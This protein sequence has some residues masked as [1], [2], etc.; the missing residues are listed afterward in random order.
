ML[1]F[2]TALRI[3]EKQGL[4]GLTTNRIAELSGFG[5]GTIY[6]YFANKQEILLALARHEQERKLAEVTALLRTQP[7]PP[8]LPGELPRIR[9]LIRALLQA[10]GGRHRARRIILQTAL[11]AGLPSAGEAAAA[12]AALLVEGVAAGPDGHDLRLDELEAY[13]LVQAVLGA[14]R[15][16][17]LRDERLLRRPAFEDALV[18][19]ISGFLATRTKALANPCPATVP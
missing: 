19:L 3:L 17:L 14:I 2:E 7:E 10:F 4:E 8:A 18:S 6:Q 12:F 13:V 5:V 9:A 1:I 11:D 16:A 15:G